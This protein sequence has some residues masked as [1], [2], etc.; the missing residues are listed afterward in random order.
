MFKAA[1]GI[2]FTIVL[3]LSFLKW[4]IPEL[5]F[6]IVLTPLLLLLACAIL[7]W[8][9]EVLFEV[10]KFVLNLTIVLLI[11]YLLSKII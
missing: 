2:A 4:L 11:L 10:F 1:F 9:I 8:I 7:A 3:V 5:P 6:F